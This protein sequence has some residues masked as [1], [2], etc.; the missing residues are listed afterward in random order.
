MSDRCLFFRLDRLGDLHTR[1][2]NLPSGYTSELWRPKGMKIKP[3]ALP[4]MPFAIWW[5]FHH[6]RVFAN[7]DYCLYLISDGQ[8]LVHRTCIFPGF[9]RFPFMRQNDLQAGNTWT[10][11][12]HRGRGLALCALAQSIRA[13]LTE[14]RH[15]WYVCADDNEA[16]IHIALK[17]GMQLV[18]KGVRTRRLG[19]LLG[20]YVL[21]ESGIN[22]P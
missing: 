10:S 8:T 19:G 14:G 13:V 21:A 15:L 12:Q 11:P 22:Q 2:G 7:R 9:F 5:L 20:A 18:G 17:A 16:S 6:A 1:L 3:S 4:L